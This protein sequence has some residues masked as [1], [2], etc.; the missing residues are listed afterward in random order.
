[1]LVLLSAFAASISLAGT[2]AAAGNTM[3]NETYVVDDDTEALRVTAENITNGTAQATIY[4]VNTTGS[5]T[6]VFT[7]ELNTT[8]SSITMDSVEFTGP[9]NTSYDY[10]VVVE[11]DGADSLSVKEVTTVSATGGG[12]ISDLSESQFAYVIGAFGLFAILFGGWA[13]RDRLL[14]RY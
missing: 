11:G 2:V 3:H 6:Q 10:R 1:M 14:G 7:A 12:G 13:I 9:F 4:E 8:S 5:E